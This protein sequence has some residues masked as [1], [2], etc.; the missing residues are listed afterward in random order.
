MYDIVALYCDLPDE[1]DPEITI[2]LRNII[3]NVDLEDVE[4]FF[5]PSIDDVTLDERVRFYIYYSISIYYRRYEHHSKFFELVRKYSMTFSLHPLNYVVLS[6][7]YRY[8]A[9]DYNGIENL[10]Y[11]IE[12]AK[13]AVSLLPGNSGVINNYAE[14]IVV[15]ID[16]KYPVQKEQISEAIDLINKIISFNG[17]Y[18]KWYYTKG[19]LLFSVKEYHEAKECVRIAIDLESADNKDSLLRI[20]QYNN[21][22]LDFRTNETIENLEKSLLDAKN[23]IIQINNEQDNKSKSFFSELDDV[24][25]KYLEFLAFFSSIIA[26]IT[27][28]INI[29]TT[30]GAATT[31]GGLIVILAG[32]LSISF[33]IFRLLISYHKKRE[34]GIVIFSILFSLLLTVSGFIICVFLR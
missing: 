26:F 3:I 21:T 33:C 32:T 7:Y 30:Y 22:L 12:N 34:I 11:A 1:T 5:S 25:S 2:K 15:A 27:A 4:H 10:K 20:A 16:E 13:K 19:K 24:K 29:V 23:E 6:L 9:I 28:S 17:T 14:L 8:Q 31:A 18:A